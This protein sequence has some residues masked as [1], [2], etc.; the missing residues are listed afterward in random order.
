MKVLLVENT[1]LSVWRG[2]EQYVDNVARDLTSDG[3]RVGVLSRSQNLEEETAWRQNA[4]LNYKYSFVNLP[5]FVYSIFPSTQTG[6]L[7]CLL[8]ADVYYVTFLDPVFLSLLTSYGKPIVLG[9]HG[10]THLNGTILKMLEP[11]LRLQKGR[12]I[13]HTLNQAQTRVFAVRGYKVWHLPSAVPMRM[14]VQDIQANDEFVIWFPSMERYK[15]ADRLIELATITSRKLPDVK[16]MV[17]GSGSMESELQRASS[18][19]GNI[20]IRH[21]L[22]QEELVHLISNANL[23]LTLSRSESF[24]RA[25]A[26]A[27]V[28]GLPTLATPT[29]GLIDIMTDSTFGRV[30]KYDA[31]RYFVSIQ[32]YYSIWKESP[33]R[34]LELKKR[35]SGLQ[36][37]RFSWGEMITQFETGI[38]RLAKRENLTISGS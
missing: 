10:I 5:K 9:L 11:L 13:I 26:E 25:A 30:M 22:T 17:T 28:N 1:P 33:L 29:D 2:V 3:F 6:R 36:R 35:I 19:L 32:N 15:G 8:D 24:S 34:Y 27:Q 12:L 7:S 21:M 37:A 38:E 23:F 18:A 20:I 14:L 4:N 31:T 16:Y